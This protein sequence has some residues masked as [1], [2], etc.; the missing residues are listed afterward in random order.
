MTREPS[1]CLAADQGMHLL[2]TLLDSLVYTTALASFL[3]ALT[4][5]ENSR[6]PVG[7]PQVESA[8]MGDPMGVTGHPNW[9]M[10]CSAGQSADST[11]YSLAGKAKKADSQI[12][13]SVTPIPQSHLTTT[14]FLLP[15]HLRCHGRSSRQLPPVRTLKSYQ[16]K[17][18]L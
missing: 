17:L 3:L 13:E 4:L 2:T 16:A 7:F 18:S 10:A 15:L 8:Y 6:L 9:T 5:T 11:G 12:K 14:P 1:R